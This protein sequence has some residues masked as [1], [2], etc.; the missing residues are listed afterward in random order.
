MVTPF[1][2]R[3][4]CLG[5]TTNVHELLTVIS[6]EKFPP[7]PES[8]QRY[9]SLSTGWLVKIWFCVPQ[10]T[11]HVCCCSNEFRLQLC[12][13]AALSN[14]LQHQCRKFCTERIHR[15]CCQCGAHGESFVRGRK[16]NSKGFVFNNS[17]LYCCVVRMGA[18][19]LT[20]SVQVFR[21]RRTWSCGCCT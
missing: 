2:V 14:C 19:T 8:N 4:L 1:W 15:V 13:E 11:K 21:K 7:P 20:V 6:T 9:S 12:V 18:W 5:K 16:K 17:D 10:Q 3:L